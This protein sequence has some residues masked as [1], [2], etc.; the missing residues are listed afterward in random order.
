MLERIDR[1]VFYYTVECALCHN[2]LKASH[3]AIEEQKGALVCTLCGRTM[4]VPDVENLLKATKTLNDYLAA[5]ENQKYI[6]LTLNEY[7]KAESDVP[8]AAH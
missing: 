6:K 2:K 3:V 8:A 1:L 4:K 7:F 5:K